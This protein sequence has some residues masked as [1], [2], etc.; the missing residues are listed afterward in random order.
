MRVQQTA[1]T[2]TSVKGVGHSLLCPPHSTGKVKQCLQSPIGTVPW[3]PGVPEGVRPQ[4]PTNGSMLMCVAAENPTPDAGSALGEKHCLSG[5][6]RA[7]AAGRGGGAR[8][9]TPL[10]DRGT[11]SGPEWPACLKPGDC[12]TGASQG[13]RLRTREDSSISDGLGSGHFHQSLPQLSRETRG[14]NLCG[15]RKDM[16]MSEGWGGREGRREVEF[17]KSS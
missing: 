9:S 3:D 13:P 12:C 10:R 1:S 2:S 7:R 8:C 16:K 6:S 14:H 5:R 11:P 17:Q 4:T 15:G